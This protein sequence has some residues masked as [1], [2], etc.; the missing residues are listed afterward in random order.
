MISVVTWGWETAVSDRFAACNVVVKKSSAII[1]M[2][3][4]V[5]GIKTRLFMGVCSPCVSLN[6]VK[7]MKITSSNRVSA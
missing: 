4:M 6:T 7:H 3:K 1:M 5:T 2:A